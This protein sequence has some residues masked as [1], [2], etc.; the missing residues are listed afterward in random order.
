LH[1]AEAALWY[2]GCCEAGMGDSSHWTELCSPSVRHHGH[3][4]QMQNKLT[5]RR[6][7]TTSSESFKNFLKAQ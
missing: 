6:W 5:L 2:G 7:Q 1:S 4:E 3:L